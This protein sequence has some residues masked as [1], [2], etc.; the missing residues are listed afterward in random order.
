[1]GPVLRVG[2]EEDLR[3]GGAGLIFDGHAPGGGGVLDGAAAGVCLVVGGDRRALRHV[4]F[5]LRELVALAGSAWLLPLLF[6]SGKRLVG[7]LAGLF[8]AVAGPRRGGGLLLGGGG[9]E[10]KDRN[11]NQD[12]NSRLPPP[13]CSHT[14]LLGESFPGRRSDRARC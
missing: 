11:S 6:R 12:A 3:L 9:E 2:D 1:M 8:G 5:Q 13:H 4:P 7:R 14:E 10:G